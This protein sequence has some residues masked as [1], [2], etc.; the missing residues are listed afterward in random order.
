MRSPL[1]MPSGK[2]RLSGL[3]IS[4]GLLQPEGTPTAVL[5][6]QSQRIGDGSER[7]ERAALLLGSGC[8]RQGGFDLFPD[9]VVA[10]LLAGLRYHHH[11]DAGLDRRLDQVAHLERTGPVRD[12]LHLAVLV[13]QVVGELGL[14]RGHHPRRK[15]FLDEAEDGGKRLLRCERPAGHGVDVSPVDDGPDKGVLAGEHRDIAQSAERS[16]VPPGLRPSPTPSFSIFGPT[17]SSLAR[18]RSINSAAG[19]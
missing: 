9:G 6:G 16:I 5:R 10:R 8:R 15:G 1:V 19:R 14:Q 18:I 11:G 13:E 3:V 17:Y 7:G 12:V 4:S 2:N